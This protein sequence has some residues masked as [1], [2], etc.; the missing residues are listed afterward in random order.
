MSLRG[1]GAIVWIHCNSLYGAWAL[2][3]GPAIKSFGNS[4]GNSYTPCLLLI[5]TLCFTCGEKKI[6]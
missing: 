6:W 3:P 5:I 1:R 2:G 4:F